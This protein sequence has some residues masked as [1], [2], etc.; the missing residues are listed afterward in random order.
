M[1]G[2][3][4]CLLPRQILPV[5]LIVLPNAYEILTFELGDANALWGSARR[6]L[7]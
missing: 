5:L 6:E 1:E 2:N 4:T 3:W 7:V